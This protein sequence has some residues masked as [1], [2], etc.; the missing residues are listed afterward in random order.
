MFMLRCDNK[1]CC[2]ESQA[3]LDVKTDEVLCSECG[4]S[5]KNVTSFTKIQMKSIG[6]IK[7]TVAA[8]KSFSI[9]CNKCLKDDQPILG[10]NDI[11]LCPNCKEELTSVSPI[12][13]GLVV[14]YLK[15][16]SSKV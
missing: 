9:K 14:E 7:R 6:Q 16:P 3:L 2:Q 4:K 13:K 11:L 8:K 10:A 1:G 15:K 5:I 12:Y